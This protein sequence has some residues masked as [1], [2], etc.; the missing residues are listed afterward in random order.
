V[1][2]DFSKWSPLTILAVAVV[3]VV[4]VGGVVNTALGH[5]TFSQ[6]LDDLKG[7]A[8]A[9]G[10]GAAV[11]RGIHFAGRDKALLTPSATATQEVV[12]SRSRSPAKKAT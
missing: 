11:G 1:T 8:A 4:V 9:L 5:E 3:L 10:V 7:I 2:V 12:R 6:Y